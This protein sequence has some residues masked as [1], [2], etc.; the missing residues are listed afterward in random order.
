[1]LEIPLEAY[2]NQSLMA[3]LNG[4]DCSIALYQ[5]NSRLYLDLSMNGSVAR[6]GAVCLPQV[7]ILGNVPGFAGD[8]VM[9]D[10]RTQPERQRPPQWEGLGT[11]WKLYYLLPAEVLTLREKAAREALH[12]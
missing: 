5:R 11:R 2:P 3:T 12:G 1:M 4:Q 10:L 8:L 6:R 7:E 9:I